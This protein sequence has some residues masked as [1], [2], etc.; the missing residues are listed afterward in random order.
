MKRAVFATT[1]FLDQEVEF[2]G[3]DGE[4][5]VL[6]PAEVVVI[7][8]NNALIFEKDNVGKIVGVYGGQRTD[9]SKIGDY[10]LVKEWAE[11]A[12]Q[13]ELSKP[14]QQRN[15]DRIIELKMLIAGINPTT[16][17]NP[18][19]SPRINNKES[20]KTDPRP[21]HS[22]PTSPTGLC[23]PSYNPLQVGN[24][25]NKYKEEN[26]RDTEKLREVFDLFGLKCVT[27]LQ[28][29]RIRGLDE[30]DLDG[31]SIVD[32][33]YTRV[34]VHPEFAAVLKE[35]GYSED[36]YSA[37]ILFDEYVCPKH[38]E[39]FKAAPSFEKSFVVE[40]GERRKRVKV[41]VGRIHPLRKYSVSKRYSAQKIE[42]LKVIVETMR[43]RGVK[44]YRVFDG[45][46]KQVAHYK[47]D[48]ALLWLVFTVPEQVS[49]G[50]RDYILARPEKKGRVE[51]LMRKATRRAIDKFL[52]KYLKKHENAPI[53]GEIKAGGMM[54]V[55]LWSSSNPLSAHVH[56]HVCLFNVVMNNGEL[57]RFTPYISKEWLR[58][59]RRIWRDEFFA[60]LRKERFS[61]IRVWIN[62]F[63][64]EDFDSFNVYN[65]YVWLNLK[66]GDFEAAGRIV[67][68]LRYNSR[69]AIVD[70]N[71]FFYGGIKAEDLGDFDREW[72]RYLVEYSNRTSNFGFMNDWR[73]SFGVS[74]EKVLEAIERVKKETHEYCPI[75]G[76]KL[77][78]K[79]TVTVDQVAERGRLL[80]LW[81][82][83]R[84]INIEVWRLRTHVGM[85]P[86]GFEPTTGGSLRV[87]AP[88]GHH[89]SADPSFITPLEPAA[90]PGYATTPCV[91]VSRKDIKFFGC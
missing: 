90:L 12:L 67:H 5:Y 20:I 31:Y 15:P 33:G 32:Y 56:N 42:Q 4:V 81:Y 60:L 73:R 2:L 36:A 85:G 34:E 77:E 13:M 53:K 57:V 44:S 46:V 43:E 55:H 35:L 7:P 26:K 75:C 18:K 14:P 51:E 9:I 84:R 78:Y 88:T 64:E 82:F 28:A 41:H 23:S 54:N 19:E 52:R 17:L 87:S 25:G 69:K 30:V 65:S 37:V 61:E 8:Y 22:Y 76:R 40:D 27:T 74:G 62:P 11:Q 45:E 47:N 58:E 49:R 10:D 48:L 83:D 59:L 86:V 38:G 91:L 72:V 29:F 24:F 80:V 89:N 1:P 39:I 6:K 21:T 66:D 3:E 16:L 79:G 63:V 68:H 70:L 50:L 71:E